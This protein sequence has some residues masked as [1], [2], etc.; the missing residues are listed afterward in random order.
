MQQ[1]NRIMII[2]K[3]G[4]GKSTF[5]IKLK[6]LLG[7]PIYHLDKYFF[8]DHWVERNYNEFIAIQNK[9]ITESTWIIDG[10]STKSYEMRYKR[11]ELCIY[12]N[13]PLWRCYLRIVKRLFYKHPNIDDRAPNCH[14]T[15]RWSLIKYLWGF[16]NRVNPILQRLRATYPSVQFVE[17]KSDRDVR[18][19]Y[20]SLGS[21][22]SEIQHVHNNI[23]NG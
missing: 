10:N 6:Q 16:E 3:S 12:F 18:L 2:G 22:H 23:D 14:E 1:F 4:S 20:N 11:A 13:F 19:F 15:I 21:L 17:L 5:A 9:M 8:V 7:I